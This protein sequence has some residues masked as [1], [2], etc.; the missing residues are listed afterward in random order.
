MSKYII[1]ESRDPFESRDT[2]FVEQTATTL[3]QDGHDVTVFLVQ[4]GV[5]ASRRRVDQASLAQMSK[6]GVDLLADDFSLCER[7]IATTDLQ[8]GIRA[9]NIDSVVT[10]L[11]QE[12]TKVIWH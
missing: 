5:L 7:G 3:K 2:E 8:E 6:A 9:S 11:I 4:N 10:A 1:I 12:D